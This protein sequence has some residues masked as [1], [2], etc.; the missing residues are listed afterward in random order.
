MEVEIIKGND[1]VKTGEYYYVVDQDSRHYRLE[2]KDGY[3]CHVL[4]ENVKVVGSIEGMAAKLVGKYENVGRALGEMTDEKQQAYGDAI[5]A[6]EQMMKVLYP[7]GVKI[8]QYRDMLLMVRIMDKQ[9]R[10]AKGDKTAFGEN[11]F[12]DIAGYGL[13]GVGHDAI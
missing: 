2:L 4:K 9:C 13:L 5:T 11:P 7:N 6:V 3:Y 1:D 10:I 8:D 12:K